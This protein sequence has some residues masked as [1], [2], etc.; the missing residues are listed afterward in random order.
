MTDAE[1]ENRSAQPTA[2]LLS[3]VV[4]VFDVE[5]Y[6]Q[7]CLES[8]ARQRVPLQVILV[9]DGS[10]DRSQDIARRFIAEDDRFELVTSDHRGLSRARNLGITAAAGEYLAFCD[11][12]DVVPEGAYERAISL[13]EG[14]AADFVSGNVLRFDS[15]KVW[16]HPR[17]REVFGTDR[18]AAHITSVRDLILDRMAW[19]KV[20]RRSF[21]NSAGLAF[22]LSEYED[23][24]VMLAAHLKA[25]AVVVTTQVA[26]HW[27]VRDRGPRSITQR[28]HEP[29]NVEARMRMAVE[30]AAVVREYSPS[31]L[32]ELGHDMT[33]GDFTV[34][35]DAIRQAPEADFSAASTLAADFVAELDAE[36]MLS[37]P[38]ANRAV[39]DG[40]RERGVLTRSADSAPSRP[41]AQ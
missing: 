10:T 22:E 21:W 37:M 14:S 5:S 33:L 13:L 15:Q 26:Y 30:S 24:P 32:R 1:S 18:Q 34:L 19:N 41:E 31:L 20:F 9:D 12:D 35:L 23:A 29:G 4:P 25:R 38:A 8:L 17:Y 16:P 2:G 28:L 11:A 3:V 7:Q 40:L 39:L 27:R 6:L 36:T